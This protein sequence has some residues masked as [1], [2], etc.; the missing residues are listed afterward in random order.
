MTILLT[1]TSSG[2]GRATA[3]ALLVKG[4]RVFGT[5][6]RISDASELSLHPAFSALIMDVTDRASIAAAIE[7][8]RTSGETL[9]AVINNSGI[10][11]SGPLETLAEEDYRRQFDVNVFGSLA[12]CQEALPLLHAAREAGEA[13]VKIINIS[14]VSGYV[15][16]PFTSIYSASKFAME[17]VTD[18]LRREL[19]PFG[20]DAVSIAPGPVK[21]PIWTKAKTQTKA[22]EGTRYAY[23]LEKLIPYV[24]NAEAGGVT[25]EHVAGVILKTLESSRPRPHQLVMPK[26]WVVRILKQLPKRVQDKIFLKNMEG[27]KRY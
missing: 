7:T 17:A 1:G 6:R 11:V 25:P 3:E 26:S 19:V 4:H 23:I 16:A 9:H 14:S 20:I 22:Y 18:G 8:I 27:N 13:N 15:T 12:V 2:I 24:E 21:T 10:A 5:V